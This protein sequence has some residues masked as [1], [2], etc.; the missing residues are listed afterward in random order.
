MHLSSHVLSNFTLRYTPLQPRTASVVPSPPIMVRHDPSELR[1]QLPRD[2]LVG[3]SPSIGVK[4]SR[5][6]TEGH[7]DHRTSPGPKPT[8]RARAGFT[9]YH[10]RW[11]IAQ[12]SD[13]GMCRFSGTSQQVWEHIRREHTQATGPLPEPTADIRC[14]WDACEYRCH[15]DQMRVHW[16]STHSVTVKEARKKACLIC[17][18]DGKNTSEMSATD[19]ARHLGSVHWKAGVWCDGCGRRVR[20]DTFHYPGRD[21]RGACLERFMKKEPGFRK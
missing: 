12:A 5:V 6:A 14:G 17:T 2:E 21:H 18:T 8:K 9:T 16:D 7:S 1:L 4:R 10:C 19:M 15:H 13:S 11:N 3:A 20:L